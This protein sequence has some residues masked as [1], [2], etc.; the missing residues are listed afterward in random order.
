MNKKE[1][2]NAVHKHMSNEG[3]YNRATAEL[4]V[5]GMIGTITNGLARGEDVVITGF[6]AFKTEGREARTGRNPKT[7]EPV[8]IPAKTVV[9]FKPGAG[10]KEKLNG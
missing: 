1:F 2:I 9:K 3:G 5:E 6:G 10:L 4:A 7:G 8:Q